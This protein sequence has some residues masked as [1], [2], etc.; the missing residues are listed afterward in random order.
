MPK[1]SLILQLEVKAGRGAQLK[2]SRKVK[3]ENQP[4]LNLAEC[5]PRA[6][7][8]GFDAVFM[9]G[10]FFPRFQ[11]DKRNPGVLALAAEAKPLTVNTDSTFAFSSLR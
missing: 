5:P 3:R 7:D 9:A 11:A 2:N 1:V 6:G 10:A 4:V 8:N